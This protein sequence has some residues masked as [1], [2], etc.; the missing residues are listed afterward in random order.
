MR[1]LQKTLIVENNQRMVTVDIRWN[2]TY[3]GQN[4]QA[5]ITTTVCIS[6]ALTSRIRPELR[7]TT[8]HPTVNSPVIPFPRSHTT[9]IAA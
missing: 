1:M 9:P 6:S 8:N 3:L 5:I 2:L 4:S 7:S